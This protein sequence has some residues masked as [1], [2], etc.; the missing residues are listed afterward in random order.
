MTIKENPEGVHFWFSP[1]E[2][3]Q[4][5]EEGD[6]IEMHGSK[7]VSVV[8]YPNMA[9]K[10]SINMTENLIECRINR[11]GDTLS[12]LQDRKSVEFCLLTPMEKS[13]IPSNIP[14]RRELG[15]TRISL[16]VSA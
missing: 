14:W 9:H 1:E 8:M 10:V 6:I 2:L 5:E 3:L 16:Q 13:N 12:R 15:T 7:K 11:K 4:L